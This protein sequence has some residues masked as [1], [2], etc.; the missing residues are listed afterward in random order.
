MVKDDNS[1]GPQRESNPMEGQHGWMGQLM[2]GNLPGLL[3][4]EGWTGA[5]VARPVCD[6]DRTTAIYRDLLGLRPRAGFEGHDGYDGAF[7]EL[8]GGGE[9]EFTT[10]PVEPESRTDE[11]LLVFHVG[12]GDEAGAIA[13]QL[14]SAGVQQI[15]SPNPYWNRFGQTFLDPD[16]SRIVIAEASPE[17]TPTAQHDPPP[18]EM[19]WHEGYREEIRPLFQLAEDSKARLDEY[20]GKAGVLVAARGSTIIGHL[21][22]VPTT[23]AGGGGRCLELSARIRLRHLHRRD[24]VRL[25]ASGPGPNAGGARA[26][27]RQAAGRSNREPAIDSDW[28]ATLTARWAFS[29]PVGM[30][31][32]Y[33]LRFG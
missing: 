21:Q 6:L 20:L 22:L 2:N 4:F 13:A 14:R 19:R 5:R 1:N 28:G 10:G 11:D 3:R 24:H 25:A 18:P 16:G 9:L 31:N 27:R 8:L 33:R 7:F 12:T 26:C 32:G 17:D 30:R 29:R 23:H 15:A